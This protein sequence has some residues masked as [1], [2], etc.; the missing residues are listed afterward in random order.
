MSIEVEQERL[1]G[2]YRILADDVSNLGIIVQYDLNKVTKND[3]LIW[4]CEVQAYAKAFI[5]V[6][7]DT[8]NLVEKQ[9]KTIM[10]NKNVRK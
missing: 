1:T 8:T 10:E 5:I 6:C 3:L 4:L 2:A 9:L 7:N